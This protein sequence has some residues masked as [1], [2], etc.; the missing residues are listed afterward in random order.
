[1]V[2]QWS[3]DG[4]KY[5]KHNIEKNGFFLDESRDISIVNKVNALTGDIEDDK[6]TIYNFVGFVTNKSDDILAILPKHYLVSDIEND[7]KMVFECIIQHMQKRPTQYIGERKDEMYTSNFPF[8]AFFGIYDYVSKYGLYFETIELIKQ[9]AGGR[10]SWK[11]TINRGIKF[12]AGSNL[13]IYPLYYRKKLNLSNFITESMICA[14]DYTLNKFSPFIDMEKT[15][16][17]MPEFDFVSEKENVVSTLLQI[18]QQIFKDVEN[19]LI[20]NLIDFYSDVDK[21]GAYYLKHYKF[22]SI[23]EDMVIDYL[24]DYYKEV[25]GNKIILDKDHAKHLS[26]KKTSFYPNAAK[27]AQFIA[28]DYY[29]ADGDTQL[30]F[31]AKYYNDFKGMDYKQIAYYFLLKE[32]HNKGQT[33][34]MFKQTLSALIAPGEKRE[35]KLHFSMNDQFSFSDI[36]FVILEEYFDIKHVIRYSLGME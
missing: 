26:F 22:S 23:W 29:V 35:T 1:M 34:P 18:K 3:N 5:D 24:K 19:E 33:T 31:D 30:I 17:D 13:V 27:T 7:T 15:G 4:K 25:S 12:Y 36:D 10:V 2:I 9:N 6:E 14:I 11:D 28:P 20:D 16:Y 21:G 8:S 32:I